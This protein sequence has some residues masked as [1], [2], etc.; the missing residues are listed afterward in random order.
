MRS[1]S[2]GAQEWL[3]E[4]EL[5][6]RRKRKQPVAGR[7][8]E[9]RAEEGNGTV[10]EIF[11]NRSAVRLDGREGRTL[12]GYRMATLAFDAAERERSPVCVGD[13]VRVEAGVIVGRCERRNKLVRPAPNSRD[14]LLH[15]V[16]ANIDILVVVAAA[17][18]PEFSAGIIDRLLVAASAQKI[19]TVLCVN[20]TDLIE[21]GM[22]RPWS[23]YTAA[24]VTLVEASASS[25]KGTEELAELLRGRT[26]AFCGHSGVG[27]TSL[28][29]RLL[30]DQRYGS[31]GPV[32]AA[33]GKG[34]HTTTGAVLLS[35]ADGSAW[36]DTPG[37]MNF[38]LLNVSPSEL[39]SHF[40]ELFRA[41]V[42]GAG[43]GH[44]AEEGCALRFLPRHGSYRRLLRSL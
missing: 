33:S 24:G 29:R 20:K 27:K 7:G 44:D 28:L 43:C 13:R 6:P 17:R 37:I 30:K 22:E 18:E 14:P 26:A 36:I 11:P 5:P 16:V 4:G 42:C 19:R 10:A 1:K 3:D 12:C 40:P 9:L 39:L 32:N 34:R 2:R 31:V 41:A 25:G 35:A 23:Q 38:A 8:R 15:A 21:P